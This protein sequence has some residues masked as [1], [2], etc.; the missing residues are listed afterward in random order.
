MSYDDLADGY[1][2]IVDNALEVAE[3]YLFNHAGSETL[4]TDLVNKLTANKPAALNDVKAS[5][6]NGAVTLTFTFAGENKDKIRYK[7]TTLTVGA[8]DNG[9]RAGYDWDADNKVAADLD[10]EIGAIINAAFRTI[11]NSIAAGKDFAS[12][13][14]GVTFGGNVLGQFTLRVGEDI[15]INGGLKV[16]GTIAPDAAN[17]EVQLAVV[18][19][20]KDINLFAITYKDTKIFVEVNAGDYSARHYIDNANLNAIVAGLLGGN[21]VALAEDGPFYTQEIE[22]LSD[23]VPSVGTVMG[24]VGGVLDVAKSDVEGGELI[25]IRADLESLL[26]LLDTLGAALGDTLAQ[27][28]AGLPAPL[29]QLDLATFTGIGGELII[30]AVIGDE[31]LTGVEI[32][33]N[34]AK[35][36]FRFSD[37]DKVQ[38]IYGPINFALAVKD[39]S[40]DDQTVVVENED[41]YTY[42]SPLNV[43]AVVDYSFAVNDGAVQ[44]YTLTLI[45]DINPFVLSQGKISLEIVGKNET[46]PAFALYLDNF[47]MEENGAYADAKAISAGNLIEGPFKPGRL[48]GYIAGG[49]SG[50]ASSS[51]F[52]FSGVVDYVQD[53][54]SMFFGPVA[55]G[56]EEEGGFDI[57]AIMGAVDNVKALYASFLSDGTIDYS[58]EPEN[59]YISADLD[60]DTY[61]AAINAVKDVLA[62]AG[63]EL[64]EFTAENAAKVNVK[65][66]TADY[67][68]QLFVDVQYK[69]YQVTV[70]GDISN[71]ALMSLTVTAKGWGEDKVYAVTADLSNYAEGIIVVKYTANEVD[72]VTATVDMADAEI[73][74][75][76]LANGNDYHFAL[77]TYTY[78]GLRMFMY[79]NGSKNVAIGAGNADGYLDRENTLAWGIPAPHGSFDFFYG[80]ADSSAEHEQSI[81]LSVKDIAIVNW[82]LETEVATVDESLV[83]TPVEDVAY[84]IAMLLSMRLNNYFMVQPQ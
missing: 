51:G 47:R 30:S 64:P 74:L 50:I 84:Q 24:L 43:E 35:K 16:T 75:D 15:N 65:V 81:Q 32:S 7:D 44:D 5:I 55:V 45:S 11:E 79:E 56:A 63:I 27:I 60:S 42:F 10:A 29:N 72:Y 49:A 3:L 23:L 48:L 70:L 8:P 39:F 83:A 53:L 31:M 62:M 17:T 40:L 80:F 21:E 66:N 9:I 68:K 12:G 41:D 61:N 2:T 13:A 20:D 69:T 4:E 76:L 14:E 22:K 52:A 26:G 6:K 77:S 18:D 78:N 82:G 37:K 28:T 1:K 46:I 59:F 33:Y 73:A 25:Q 67:E 19:M 36:D 71:P 58:F 57:G 38:K 54:M 34:A